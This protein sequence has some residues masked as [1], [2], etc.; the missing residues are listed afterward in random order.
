MSK[1]LIILASARKDSN[2]STFIQRIFEK[3]E[4]HLIDLLNHKVYPYNYEEKY[5]SDDKFIPIVRQLT[6]HQKIIWATPVYWYAMSSILK[7]FFDRFTDL[8]HGY[9]EIRKKLKGRHTD[10]LAVGSALELPEGFEVP[11]RDTAHYFDM[12]FNSSYYCPTKYLS[13]NSSIFIKIKNDI[14]GSK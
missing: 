6:N 11:F 7:K 10:L 4:Y 13:K 3:E 9:K 12:H 14:I 1:P 5:P 2:T 8:T